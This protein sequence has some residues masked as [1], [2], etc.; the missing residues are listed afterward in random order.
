MIIK[1][2]VNFTEINEK[3]VKL[4]ENAFDEKVRV[5]ANGKE[6]TVFSSTN[7]YFARVFGDDF[8]DVEVE[9]CDDISSACIAPLRY[10]REITFS[11]KRANFKVKCGD[12]ISVEFNGNIAKPVFIFADRKKE[13]NDYNNCTVIKYDD[14]KIYDAG[15][16][17]PESN[18]V[19]YIGENTIVRGKIRAEYADN[20]K[21]ISNGIFIADET[22]KR[23][24]SFYRCK[25]IKI[26]G[27]V[28][29]GRG[30]W[31]TVFYECDNVFIEDYK[32]IGDIM[33]SDGIDIC[34]TANV[35]IH[36]YFTRNEDDCLCIKTHTQTKNGSDDSSQKEISGDVKNVYVS[37]CVLFCGI[38]GNG[39]E[40]GYELMNSVVSNVVFRNI[41]VI[42]RGTRSEKF[43]R[44]VISIHNAGNATVKDVLFENV[45]AQ[46]TEE[47][48]IHVVPICKKIW[49]SGRG[50]MEN[51]TFRNIELIGG[52]DAPSKI[53]RIPINMDDDRDLSD[54]KAEVSNIVFE[55]VK[56]K[57]T[58]LD[59][60]ETARKCGFEIDGDIDVKFM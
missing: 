19:L 4:S 56:Y 21:I 36:H 2:D 37:D 33:C 31:V 48:F 44:S 23:T 40:I 43:N 30:S 32:V 16:L 1:P 28:T 34:C 7:C 49:G 38:R 29:V 54:D 8:S 39:I 13:L 25:N 6:C 15:T 45:S 42:H 52:Y 59:S 60:A 27:N 17:C 47:N 3:F 51:V 11:G 55:N 35:Y 46:Y 26:E 12:Y 41:D 58:W 18:T 9:Y 20:I 5:F 53:S 14:N 50:K 57:G 22:H 24:M 10:K